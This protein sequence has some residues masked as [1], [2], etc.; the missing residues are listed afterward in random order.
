MPDDDPRTINELI[1]RRCAAWPD[2]PVQFVRRDGAWVPTTYGELG[3]RIERVARG[4]DALGVK[5]G[6][7]VA[8]LCENRPEWAVYDLAILALGAASVPIYVS[9]TPPQVGYVLADAGARVACT[10][11]V[12]LATKLR[13]AC[14]H[15]AQL[16]AIVCADPVSGA[17]APLVSLA[18]LEAKG[19]ASTLDVRARA[20]EAR[21]ED[22]ASLI[23]TSGTTGNPKGVMLTH[24]N[25]ATNACD[26][27]IA[28]E[29]GPTDRHV[30][31]LPLCHVFE[32]TAGHYLMLH[33]GAEIWYVPAIDQVV[34]QLPEIRPT[35]FIS[36][37]R[38]YEKIRDAM[39]AKIAAKPGIGGLIARWA[40]R[41]GHRRTARVLAGRRGW[42]V[43]W[44]LA[45]RLVLSKLRAR[46]GGRVK[47]MCSGGAGLPVPI[48]RFFHDI[49]L[50]ILEGYGLTET[51]PVVSINLPH[52]Y[53]PGTVGPPIRRVEVKI[54]ADG[55]ILVRGPN[56]MRGY[57][58]RPEDT[59]RAINA[60]GWFATGDIGELDS[61]GFLK[62]TDRK[63]D[64]LVTSGG[65]N[66]APQVLEGHFKTDAFIGEFVVCGD[67][68]HYLTA[69]VVPDF[70]VLE[71]WARDRGLPT[72]KDSLVRHPDVLALY[73][74]RIDALSGTIARYEQIKRFALVATDFSV[75]SGLVTPT[76]KVRRREVYTRFAKEIEEMYR[77]EGA[78]A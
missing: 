62:I 42:S 25:F 58:N 74:A 14:A 18:A 35:L 59:A 55:E 22:L 61:D 67:A 16:D 20:A 77:E 3:R 15:G 10:S 68:R 46:F 28:L 19:E 71:P 36:V 4:L 38:L 64:L 30:S 41:V 8:I 13:E 7:R 12:E 43:A 53:K 66:V 2:K 32:R 11:G 27:A 48:W 78:P 24:A 33:L 54:A 57:F 26:A 39:T 5:K 17:V 40:L 51:S 69:I 31:F 45:D 63:K 60:E 6:D 50:V 52:R 47:K 65:K 21:P 75:A 23:Y 56:V 9:L 44:W 49:G 70:A 1:A 76:M 37:P 29:I 72:D 73:R 34:N